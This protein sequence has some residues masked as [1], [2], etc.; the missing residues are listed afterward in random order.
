[1]KTLMNKI[2]GL[3]TKLKNIINNFNCTHDKHDFSEAPKEFTFTHFPDTVI[4]GYYGIIKQHI[5]QHTCSHCNAVKI[6]R[7]LEEPN[8]FY[9][10]DAITAAELINPLKEHLK[11][12]DKQKKI[13][14]KLKRTKKIDR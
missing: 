12:V 10:P 7:E 1:M 13:K 2:T 9:N 11:E 5:K 3:P 14:A 6:I 8:G 4:K